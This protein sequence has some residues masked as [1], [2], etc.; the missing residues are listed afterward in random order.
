MIDIY[1]ATHFYL[2]RASDLRAPWE[3]RC[4]QCNALL[5]SAEELQ[6]HV[7]SAH[8]NTAPPGTA[9]HRKALSKVRQRYHETLPKVQ[10]LRGWELKNKLKAKVVGMRLAADDR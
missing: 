10:L 9:V 7:D 6:A 1:F 4:S 5:T 8:T 2:D 3:S